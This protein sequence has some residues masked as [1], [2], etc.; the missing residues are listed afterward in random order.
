MQ[1]NP[2]E[3][4]ALY[5]A[6]KREKQTNSGLFHSKKPKKP[7]NFF[8][9]TLK[10]EPR[11]TNNRNGHGAMIIIIILIIISSRRFPQ[12]PKVLVLQFSWK[13]FNGFNI[14]II[15]IENDLMDMLFNAKSL[16]LRRKWPISFN[17]SVLILN[18]N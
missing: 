16:Y 9:K 6:K 17:F 8:L 14:I 10:I 13:R 11:R 1:L 12:F 7:T 5:Q 4:L 3:K 15:I 2:Y 18:Q